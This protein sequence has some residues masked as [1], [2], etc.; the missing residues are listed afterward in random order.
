MPR[1]KQKWDSGSVFKVPLLDDSYVVG[2]V[3]EIVPELSSFVG[4]FYNCRTSSEMTFSIK[5]MNLSNPDIVYF[6]TKNHIEYGLWPVVTSVNPK[7]YLDI[8]KIVN[9]DKLKSGDIVGI[10]VITSEVIVTAFDILNH[11]CP[12]TFAKPEYI[13]SLFYNENSMPLW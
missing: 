1:K 13:E 4:A 2:L 7:D 6:V 3:L 9:Y 8:A 11:L 12:N 5:D 10:N